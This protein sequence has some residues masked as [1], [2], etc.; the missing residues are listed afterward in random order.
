MHLLS[1]HSMP[2]SLCKYVASNILTLLGSANSLGG[3]FLRKPLENAHIAWRR[4]LLPTF[5][6]EKGAYRQA[7]LAAVFTY[8]QPIEAIRRPARSA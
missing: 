2:V 8:H 5:H 4:S 6:V 3:H 1:G 7:H